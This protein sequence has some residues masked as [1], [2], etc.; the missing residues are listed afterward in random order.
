MN[1]R[2]AQI[3]P[4]LPQSGRCGFGRK[5]LV[6]CLI[7]P[8]A[9]MAKGQDALFNAISVQGAINNA[10]STFVPAPDQP[11]LGPVRYDLGAYTS[12]TYSDNINGAQTNAESDVISQTGINVELEWPATEHSD[13]IVNTS[14]GYLHYFK[15]AGNNGLEVSP[16]SVLNYSLSWNDASLNFYDQSTYSRQV[17][18]EAALANEVTVPQFGNTSGLSGEWDPGHWTF[19]T[20]YSHLINLS[21][22]AHNYL[23]STL[24]EFFGRAGWRFA[25]ATQAGVEASYSLTSYQVA[26][27]SNNSSY[28]VGAY[29]Q[30]QIKPWLQLIIR[31]G[32]T[33]YDFYSQSQG[34]ANSSLD[35]YYIS[36]ALNHQISDFLSQ[37]LAVNRS[38][39]LGLNQGSDYVEQLTIGYS[40]NWVLTQRVNLS[41]SLTYA[42]GQQPFEIGYLIDIPGILV[43][44]E[45]ATENYQLYSGGLSASWQFTD[46]LGA[47]LSYSHTQRDSNLS[48]RT[49]A[50][51]SITLQLNYHF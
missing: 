24:E 49:Y 45:E 9:F 30:W 12:L 15:Y 11:H 38:I 29:G 14:I 41:A 8:V 7:S 27:Q 48:D 32:P 5:A 3:R 51:D 10:S 31:G 44:P 1:R 37:N 2:R 17:T 39:Q 33:F 13:L 34:V 23:N 26:S 6:L 22:S 42:D 47:T 28:S 19:Q 43:I 35:S 4:L 18:T 25:E 20:S 46:H 21:D 36:L 50:A 16:N 40:L